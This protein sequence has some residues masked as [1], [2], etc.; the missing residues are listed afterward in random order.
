MLSASDK[1]WI[2]QTVSRLVGIAAKELGMPMPRL[3][4][5]QFAAAVE[6]NPDVILRKIRCG[7]I[8][9]K[10]VFGERPKKISPKALELFGVTPQEAQARLVAR[11]LWRFEQ[12]F[13][14]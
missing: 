6:H 9:D 4:V 8:P 3:T 2:E 1:L 11:N 12:P 13:A 5:R 7:V 14:A 10:F